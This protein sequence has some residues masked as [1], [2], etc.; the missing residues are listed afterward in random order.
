M[1]TKYII[2]QK[3]FTLLKS[4]EYKK[5]KCF[6]KLKNN[7]SGYCKVCECNRKNIYLHIRSKKHINNLKIHELL[8]IDFN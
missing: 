6:I 7:T 5:D 1:G 4:S 8:T 2:E 3:T